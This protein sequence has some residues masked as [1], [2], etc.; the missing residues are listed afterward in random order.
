MLYSHN[1][2]YLR[3]HFILEILKNSFENQNQLIQPYDV[4]INLKHS[5]QSCIFQML[6]FHFNTCKETF[7]K[8]LLPSWYAWDIYRNIFVY[9]QYPPLVCC[10]GLVSKQ[11]GIHHLSQKPF[12]CLNTWRRWFHYFLLHTRKPLCIWN[13]KLD[14]AL[15]FCKN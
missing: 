5:T 1:F 12:L 11:E 3:H 10:F 2:F 15:L 8:W 13:K 9:H 4:F 7:A 6:T 14:V